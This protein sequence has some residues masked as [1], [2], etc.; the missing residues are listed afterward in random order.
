MY[1]SL[2]ELH[3]SLEDALS[4]CLLQLGTFLEATHRSQCTSNLYAKNSTAS[5]L[6]IPVLGVK[7]LHI[8][9]IAITSYYMTSSTNFTNI[10]DALILL[11]PILF[12][13]AFVFTLFLP[14]QLV[15]QKYLNAF[16]LEYSDQYQ[17]DGGESTKET[18]DV[19]EVV[20]DGVHVAPIVNLVQ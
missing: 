8:S 6:Y 10:L 15:H 2:K 3:V 19:A 7:D 13:T 4:L 14:K 1:F 20:Q 11:F 17:A 9:F 16:R 12:T 5:P 18:T